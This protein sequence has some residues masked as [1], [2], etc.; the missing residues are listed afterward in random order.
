MYLATHTL[1]ET[2][3][4]LRELAE[5]FGTVVGSS[6]IRRFDHAVDF[7]NFPLLETDGSSF[8]GKSAKPRDYY[9]DRDGKGQLTGYGIGTGKIRANIYDKTTELGLPGRERKRAI[10]DRRHREAGRLPTDR[11]TRIEFQHDGEVLRELDINDEDQ[12][13]AQVERLWQYD[14]R[15]WLRLIDPSSNSRRDRCATDPRWAAVQN[16]VCSFDAPPLLRSRFTV[17]GPSRALAEGIV[18]SMLSAGGWI[19]VLTDHQL[20]AIANRG[21]LPTAYWAYIYGLCAERSGRVAGGASR[22]LSASLLERHNAAV[23]RHSRSRS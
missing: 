23:A 4:F 6:R 2:R 3:L 19:D 12:L 8:V 17:G 9:K 1:R 16:A 11:V 15:I 10:E 5:S 13:E 14:T 20:A 21:D 18:L 22:D 7:A